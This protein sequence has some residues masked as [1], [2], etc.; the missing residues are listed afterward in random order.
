MSKGL[1]ELYPD[2]PP[3]IQDEFWNNVKKWGDSMYKLESTNNTSESIRNR[4]LNLEDMIKY[5]YGIPLD[6]NENRLREYLQN[7][8]DKLNNKV[9]IYERLNDS[10]TECL[11]RGDSPDSR[12]MQEMRSSYYHTYNNIMYNVV[13]MRDHMIKDLNEGN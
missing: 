6:A 13:I 12:S 5:D 8:Y 4:I 1:Q 10:Y 2:I 7:T 3:K 11:E 9:Q